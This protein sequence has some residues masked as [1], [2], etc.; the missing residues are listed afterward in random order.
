MINQEIIK[1]LNQV[2][3]HYVSHTS[4]K[5]AIEG[6]ENSILLSE[7]SREPVNVMLTGQAGTGKTTACNA[8][9]SSRKRESIVKDNYEITLVPAFYTLI[10]NPVTIKGVASALL[11][12]LGDPSPTKGTVVDLTFRLGKLLSSCETKVII[13]DELQHL[14]KRDNYGRGDDVKDWL[15]ALINAYGVPIIVVG[16]PTCTEIINSDPQLARRFTTRFELNNLDYGA[17]R[18]G[19]FRKFIE[20]LSNAFTSILK[21][22]DF[23]DFRSRYKSTMLFYATGGNPSD[24]SKLFKMATLNAF[25]NNRENVEFTDFEIAFDSLVLPN[26]LQVSEVQKYLNPFRLDVKK[27]DIAITNATAYSK[28]KTNIA[29]EKGVA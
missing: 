21:L 3:S 1:R 8:V 22:S 13:L 19:D 11:Q 2:D 25:E 9:L 12:S 5:E 29:E 27:L 15:K 20:E 17:K 4:I 14:L 18:K 23:P 6:I 24:T 10:P 26:T 7:G 16:T 28:Y